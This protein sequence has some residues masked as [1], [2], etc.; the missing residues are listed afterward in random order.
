MEAGGELAEEGAICRKIMGCATTV[1]ERALTENG[2]CCGFSG[3]VVE[4]WSE[5]FNISLRV[6]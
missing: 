4:M 3:V 6:W 5:K 2:A 1:E